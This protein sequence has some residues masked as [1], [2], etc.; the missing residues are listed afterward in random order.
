MAM[1]VLLLLHLTFARDLTL[2]LDDTMTEA[3]GAI[4]DTVTKVCKEYLS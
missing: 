3:A 1:F 2:A 4:K